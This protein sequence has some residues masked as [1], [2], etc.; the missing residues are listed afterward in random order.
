MPDSGVLAATLK[1]DYLDSLRDKPASHD[2][3]FHSVMGWVGARADFNKAEWDLL[4]GYR[5]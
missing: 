4:A 3:L 5:N 2:K 1:P